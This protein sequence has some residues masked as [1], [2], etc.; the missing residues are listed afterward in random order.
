MTFR[1]ST[2][3][4]NQVIAQAHSMSMAVIR[5]L[6]CP[7]CGKGTQIDNGPRGWTVSQLPGVAQRRTVQRIGG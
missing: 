6:T 5:I 4:C 2:P 7:K 3:D 1:C